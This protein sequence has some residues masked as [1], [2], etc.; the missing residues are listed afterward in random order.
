M[1][2]EFRE[3]NLVPGR[4]PLHWK[5]APPPGG[6][7]LDATRQACRW[8]GLWGRPPFDVEQHDFADTERLELGFDLG[9][10]A[11]DVDGLL[12]A[13]SAATSARLTVVGGCAKWQGE[14]LAPGESRDIASVV[15][16]VPR[17]RLDPTGASLFV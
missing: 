2:A 1:P 16:G 9:A 13:D 14:S 10:I 7:C 17:F 11:D 12:L 4:L 5:G 8:S 3:F 15:D 6:P